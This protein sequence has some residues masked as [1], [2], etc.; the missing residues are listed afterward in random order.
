MLQMNIVRILPSDRP[1]ALLKLSRL[2]KTMII[3]IISP[4][5]SLYTDKTCRSKVGL[6][7]GWT[8]QRTGRTGRTQEDSEDWRWLQ[9][10]PTCHL[11]THLP[12]HQTIDPEDSVDKSTSS[13]RSSSV[14]ADHASSC[15][16]HSPYPKHITSSSNS[17]LCHTF[18]PLQPQ[19]KRQK[20][21][22]FVPL[23]PLIPPSRI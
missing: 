1:T 15:S 8:A 22:P 14:S 19:T 7:C 16:K 17:Q 11:R 6:N 5:A 12:Q 21:M 9:K 20:I 3:M 2:N 4:V 18:P 13:T 23:I 10:A